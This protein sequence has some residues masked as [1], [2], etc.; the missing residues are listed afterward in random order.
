MGHIGMY[1]AVQSLGL[2]SAGLNKHKHGIKVSGLHWIT[3]FLGKGGGG[4]N[5]GKLECLIIIIY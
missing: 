1:G 2:R 3:F 5:V 4:C